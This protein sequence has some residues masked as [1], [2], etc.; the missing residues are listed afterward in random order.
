MLQVSLFGAGLASCDGHPID[1]FGGHQSFRLLCYLL[2]NRHHSHHRER[3]AAVFWGD[4]PTDVS[5]KYLRNALWRLRSLFQSAGI[6]AGEYLTASDDR[7]SFIT[8]SRYWLDVEI[9][10]GAI[11]ACQKIP[12]EHFTIEHAASLERAADLYAGDL[13][14]D[15]YED[16]CLYDRE[17]LRLLYLDTLSK[18]MIF[19]ETHGTY[20]YGLA[21]GERFLARDRT[22]EKAHRQM[23]RLYWRVGDRCAALTQY[24]QCVQIL[25]EEMGV[26]PTEQTRQLYQQMI[27]GQFHPEALSPKTIV[28]IA[29]H[30]LSNDSDLPLATQVLERLR[31]LQRVTDETAAELR[32]IEALV[33]KALIDP[34]ALSQQSRNGAELYTPGHGQSYRIPSEE[35]A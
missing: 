11:A 1:G 21:Y 8:S 31:H 16:W 14:E 23:M 29:E 6:P 2:L 13:L 20:E 27:H 30:L 4:Y 18:L 12:A 26:A 9:F 3:L 10:E 32:R 5:R 17:R 35:T 7:V 28:P 22:R 33:Q 25:R 19:H 24:K 34:T 15:L